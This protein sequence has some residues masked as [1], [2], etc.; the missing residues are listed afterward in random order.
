MRITV[1][2]KVGYAWICCENFVI[3]AMVKDVQEK[4]RYLRRL[5]SRKLSSGSMPQ[6]PI[7]IRPTLLQREREKGSVQ[8][9]STVVRK[10]TEYR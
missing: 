7:R 4:V 9:S 3:I 8:S 2:R 10:V 6:P 5:A 1:P